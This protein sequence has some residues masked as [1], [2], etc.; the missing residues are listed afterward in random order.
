MIL[1]Q[2]VAVEASWI[3]LNGS[4]CLLQR[5]ALWVP[6]ANQAAW[7]LFCLFPSYRASTTILLPEHLPVTQWM[8]HVSGSVTSKTMRLS[9][10]LL[11]MSPHDWKCSVLQGN[12]KVVTHCYTTFI[13]SSNLQE[14]CCSRTIVSIIIYH[15]FPRE[16]QIYG[17]YKDYK[18]WTKDEGSKVRVK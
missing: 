4:W 11:P 14:G 8:T 3:R 7:I 17:Y 15:T 12:N 2:S 10:Y 5:S 16:P 18:R 13:N 1:K 9:L 6:H